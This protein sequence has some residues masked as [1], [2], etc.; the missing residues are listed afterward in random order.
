M[1]LRLRVKGHMPCFCLQV[2]EI[3]YK[4]Y[5]PTG[6]Y[7]CV[8]SKHHSLPSPCVGNS[9]VV[10]VGAL[11]R[12]IAYGTDVLAL[13]ALPLPLSPQSQAEVSAGASADRDEIKRFFMDDE[14][15][16]CAIL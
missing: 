5:A 15:A 9:R 13:R 2:G 11:T 4:E 3:T 14:R 6:F 16:F 12:C 8:A 7:R 10:R 1:L